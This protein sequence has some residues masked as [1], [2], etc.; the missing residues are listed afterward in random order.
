MYCYKLV[1][2]GSL[3]VLTKS[4]A[5]VSEEGVPLAVGFAYGTMQYKIL[6]VRYGIT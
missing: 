1:A 3:P 5:E 4:L 2:G 6:A